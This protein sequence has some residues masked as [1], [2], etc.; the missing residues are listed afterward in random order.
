MPTRLFL[1]LANLRH[2][3][4]SALP[5][6]LFKSGTS[7]DL[8]AALNGLFNFSSPAPKGIEY[9]NVSELSL[10]LEEIGKRLEAYLQAILD[11]GS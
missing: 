3:R 4:G 11:S 7:P 6:G 9:G 2:D 5:G 8:M 1:R 10:L